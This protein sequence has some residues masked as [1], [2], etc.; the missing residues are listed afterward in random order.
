MASLAAQP[1][2]IEADAAKARAAEAEAALAQVSHTAR[3]ESLTHALQQKYFF[4]VSCGQ[5][6]GQQRLRRRWDG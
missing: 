6:L 5:T 2:I 3:K 1:Y 4:L